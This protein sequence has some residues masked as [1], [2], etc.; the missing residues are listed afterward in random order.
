[1]SVPVSP[2]KRKQPDNVESIGGEY[3]KRPRSDQGRPKEK[4]S[5]KGKSKASPEGEFKLV[6]AS[7]AVSIPPLFSNDAM[8]GV[9]EMLDS[10]VM[11]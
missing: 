7:I 5:K 10:L 11:R 2:K 9:L 3:S 8:R 4:K 6:K 1:M